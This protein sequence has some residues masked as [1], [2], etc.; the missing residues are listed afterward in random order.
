VFG[1]A[2]NDTLPLPV[3]S[4]LTTRTQDTSLD[5]LHLQ[6]GTVETETLKGPP[7]AGTREEEL[8]RSNRHAAACWETATRLPFRT[9]TADRSIAAG[10]SATTTLTE[11]SPWPESG[12][13]RTH[14]ASLSMFHRHSR[15]VDTVAVKRAADGATEV[16]RPVKAVW[17]LGTEPG[18]VV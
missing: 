5:A 6:P 12:V 16:G 1:S 14:D 10:F 7:S 17:H 11:A 2:T 18:P 13:T 8:A 15:V 9:R 4:E 3:C